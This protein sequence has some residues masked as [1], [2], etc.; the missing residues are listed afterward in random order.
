MLVDCVIES[1]LW[2]NVGLPALAEA[3][4]QACFAHLGLAVGTCEVVLLGCDNARI[5][6][7]NGDFR[8]KNQPTNVLSWPGSDRAA[9]TVGAMPDLSLSAGEELGDIALAYETCEAEALAAGRPFAA[10]ISH[11]TIHGLLH[12]LGFDHVQDAD[13]A[14]M[15]QLE[16]EILGNMG[17]PDP[18]S[19]KS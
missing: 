3:A 9:D 7:L 12:L 8:A 13:A 4:A 1:A 17:L 19:D 6:A 11:L 18:Y 5:A 15:E 16:R 10:H 14:L 2:D